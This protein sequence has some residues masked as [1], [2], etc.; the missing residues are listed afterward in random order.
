M[1]KSPDRFWEIDALR[2]IA[3]VLMIIFH[4]AFDLS[5]FGGYDLN[6][7]SGLWWLLGRATASIFILLAGIA[8]SLSFSGGSPTFTSYLKRGLW[9][10]LWGLLITAITWLFFPQEFIVFGV[11]HFIGLSSVIAYPL[12]RYRYRNL[13]IGLAVIII[14]L[15]LKGPIPLFPHSFRTF[16]YFP[17]FPWFGLFLIGIFLGNSLYPEHV[18]KFSIP[19]ISS[20][21]STLG[22][23]SLPI[24]LIHQPV[25]IALLYA[26]GIVA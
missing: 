16:D 2:G 12:I 23:H 5:Y 20:P 26:L 13:F 15:S 14:G 18:R 7:H 25:L 19:E 8:I 4:L 21:L 6:I 10:F 24:Y 22:Q 11:L 3:I 9:V 17:L 1:T